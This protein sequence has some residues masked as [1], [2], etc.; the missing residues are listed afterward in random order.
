MVHIQIINPLKEQYIAFDGADIIRNSDQLEIGSEGIETV[1][2]VD[3]KIKTLSYDSTSFTI[4]G[5]LIYDSATDFWFFDL[6]T[7]SEMLKIYVG[8]CVALVIENKD[9][10]D[11]G[12]VG[13]RQFKINE[14]GIYCDDIDQT[15]VQLPYQLEFNG[16]GGVSRIAWY[17]SEENMGLTDHM[18]FWAKLFTGSIGSSTYAMS[19]SEIT[20]RGSLNIINLT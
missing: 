16:E 12:Y 2:S 18:L 6:E 19:P 10:E 1:I 9:P 3:I 13:M 11:E 15:L 8:K 14:F 7:F 20:H 17:D 4:S 5:E